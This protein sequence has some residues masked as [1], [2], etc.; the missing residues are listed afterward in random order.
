MDLDDPTLVKARSRE[1]FFEPCT[2]WLIEKFKDYTVNPDVVFV[3]GAVLEGDLVRVFGGLD[4][5]FTFSAEVLLKDL[6]ES[7]EYY[8]EPAMAC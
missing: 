2:D 8:K 7:M 4:D 5:Q 1:P 3:S 6:F